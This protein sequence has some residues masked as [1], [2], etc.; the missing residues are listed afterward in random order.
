MENVKNCPF[1]FEE[2]KA[3]AIKCKH[4]SS[5][6][7][8]AEIDDVQSV[9]TDK[10]RIILPISWIG[11]FIGVLIAV[12][13]GIWTFNYA[14]ELNYWGLLTGFFTLVAVAAAF[15]RGFKC[16]YCQ[17]DNS[18]GLFKE[19]EKCTKCNTLHII[20]WK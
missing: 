3:E 17:K 2:I 13:L 6:I 11:V 16:S 10:A 8:S 12:V 9:A 19:N 1:C 4:C 15:T 20:D 5:I 14:K 7:K 18:I